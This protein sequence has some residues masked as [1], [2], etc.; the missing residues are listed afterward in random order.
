MSDPVTAPV[1]VPVT[2]PL[3]APVAN[4]TTLPGLNIRAGGDSPAQASSVEHA[5]DTLVITAGAPTAAQAQASS[6]APA[7]SSKQ[8]LTRLEDMARQVGIIQRTWDNL[9]FA[10]QE[11]GDPR[12]PASVT[13]RAALRM[14]DVLARTIQ[15]NPKL[16]QYSR[17]RFVQLWVDLSPRPAAREAW[18][19]L[20]T[21]P[22]FWT[23]VP[24]TLRDTIAWHLAHNGGRPAF[25]ARS[26]S[27]LI[28]DRLFGQATYVDKQHALA[29][30]CESAE[31]VTKTLLPDPATMRKQ[32]ARLR[33]QHLGHM[34]PASQQILHDRVMTW[35]RALQRSFFAPVPGTQPM[36]VLGQAHLGA[37]GSDWY[38]QCLD[39][40]MRQG[41]ENACISAYNLV[42]VN[43]GAEQVC[44]RY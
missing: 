2:A 10:V 19:A 1:T 6:G 22:N 7:L 43:H 18:T 17:D 13:S 21:D 44:R 11:N 31:L 3:S 40:T 5:L 35:A 36:R 8:A 38:R 32:A 14:L 9:K 27:R 33:K 37:F 29:A 34:K 25:I 30:P 39:L 41:M 12:K 20:G 42:G 26:V 15:K 4:L 28:G 24:P 23:Q 16:D